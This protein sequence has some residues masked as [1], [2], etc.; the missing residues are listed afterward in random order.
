MQASL[1]VAFWVA[2]LTFPLMQIALLLLAQASPDVI[3][4]YLTTY[5]VGINLASFVP[6]LFAVVHAIVFLVSDPSGWNVA[7]ATV[8]GI[9]SVLVVISLLYLQSFAA[10][11]ALKK[12]IV[13]PP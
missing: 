10:E 6:F 1:E 5:G 3:I 9:V 11:I 2:L 8:V 4:R 13:T 7:T 12:S